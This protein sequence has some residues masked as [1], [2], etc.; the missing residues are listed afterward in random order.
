VSPAKQDP[1]PADAS[2]RAG[3]VRLLQVLLIGGVIAVYAGAAIFTGG[4]SFDPFKDEVQLWAQAQEFAKD[5]PP[6]LAELRSYREPMTPAA[7]LIWAGLE[8]WHHQGIAAARLATMVAALVVLLAIALQPAAPGQPKTAP[9]L[10]ALGLVLYPYWLPLSILVYTDVPASLFVLGGFF[11][12]VRDRHAAGAV[13][14]ALAIATRQYAVTYPLAIVAFEGIAALR[15]RSLMPARW[16]P[17]LVAASTLVAWFAFFG[18]GLSPGPSYEAWPRHAEALRTIQPSYALHALAAL[19]IYF[20]AVELALERGPKSLRWR[21][22][23]GTWLALAAALVL[24]AIFTPYTPEGVGL[25]NRGL[26]LAIGDPRLA[27]FVLIPLQIVAM[28]ATIV[29]FAQ[30]GL[31]TWIVAG[32]VAVMPLS[33]A[34]WEKYYMGTLVALWFLKAAGALDPRHP[35]SSAASARRGATIL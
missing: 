24:F 19:G 28:C 3:R 14:F 31:G 35:P 32:N 29:R 1:S 2:P 10:A 17:Y 26:H 27:P 6:S 25:L 33:W 30:P 9:V 13:C 7:F 5:F 4:L 21:A 22:D 12:Y 18:G 34:P 23:R 16:L 20:V 11:F 15:A 8:S